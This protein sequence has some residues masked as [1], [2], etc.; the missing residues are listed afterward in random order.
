M[1]GVNGWFSTNIFSVTDGEV[2]DSPGQLQDKESRQAVLT[3]DFIF[4][5]EKYRVSTECLS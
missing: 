3:I 5:P 4:E 2:L 1:L